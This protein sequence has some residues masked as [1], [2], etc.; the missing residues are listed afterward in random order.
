M[1]RKRFGYMSIDEIW[2]GPDGKSC[3]TWFH[4]VNSQLKP[5]NCQ[6]T[7]DNQL[8][9]IVKWIYHYIIGM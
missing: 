7:L 2:C 4:G 5:R 6:G 9:H 1:S 8:T 3:K